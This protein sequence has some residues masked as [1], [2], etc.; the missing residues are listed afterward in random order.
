MLKFCSSK[1]YKYDSEKIGQQEA[2]C[3]ANCE[4]NYKFGMEILE[5]ET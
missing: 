4:K 1:C 3:F 2:D 5:N